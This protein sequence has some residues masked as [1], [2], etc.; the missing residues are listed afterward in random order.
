MYLGV[1]CDFLR[2]L[3]HVPA[4][5]GQAA[6]FRKSNG[7]LSP[8]RTFRRPHKF[9]VVNYNENLFP[10]RSA[11]DLHIELL[12]SLP[13]N[14]YLGFVVVLKVS[15]KCINRINI[16][17]GKKWRGKHFTRLTSV[18]TSHDL[19]LSIIKYRQRLHK[20]RKKGK[21]KAIHNYFSMLFVLGS[22]RNGINLKPKK[23]VS[24]FLR[25]G[26]GGD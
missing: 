16:W 13:P 7:E 14:K 11:S 24:T 19:F 22:I 18:K 5:W 9:D 17:P 4:G 20:S 21:R 1:C 2:I 25:W 26:G 23:F 12:F 6:P 8:K 10:L 3:L 15:G